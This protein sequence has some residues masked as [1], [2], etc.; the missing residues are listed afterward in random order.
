ME[1]V[2]PVVDQL[3][4]HE[5]EMSRMLCGPGACLQVI[6]NQVP[7][8]EASSDSRPWE[9]SRT[10]KRATFHQGGVAGRLSAIHEAVGASQLGF[11]K[12]QPHR[13]PQS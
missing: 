11:S 12:G 10:S 13:C 5:G 7:N 8:G 4:Y 3:S 6:G 1:A 9:L 2:R